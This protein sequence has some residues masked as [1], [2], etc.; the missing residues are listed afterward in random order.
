MERVTQ[1]ISSQRGNR[2]ESAAAT[3]GPHPA[4]HRSRSFRAS[5]RAVVCL[6]WC[7]GD[8]VWILSPGKKDVMEHSEVKQK[9]TLKI[10]VLLLDVFA[11]HCPWKCC[12]WSV[13]ICSLAQRSSL[14][15]A[16][17]HM[18][19]QFRMWVHATGCSRPRDGLGRSPASHSGNGSA[20]VEFGDFPAISSHGLTDPFSLWDGVWTHA[21]TWRSA[22]RLSRSPNLWRHEKTVLLGRLSPNT[23]LLLVDFNGKTISSGFS[24]R[25]VWYLWLAEGSWG[26]NTIDFTRTCSFQKSQHFV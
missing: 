22:A 26:K 15:Y 1:V 24:N 21:G 16:C 20:S 17:E 3:L 2:S 12:T 7:E 11:L 5:L 13:R 23:L 18:L 8:L 19:L 6:E 10:A 9:D 14:P 4:A 25:H